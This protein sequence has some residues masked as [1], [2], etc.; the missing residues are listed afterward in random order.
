MFDDMFAFSKSHKPR[1]GGKR[2]L[3]D[4]HFMKMFMP[5]TYAN[6]NKKSNDKNKKN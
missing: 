1:V 3:S 5:K 6:S 4:R 2:G